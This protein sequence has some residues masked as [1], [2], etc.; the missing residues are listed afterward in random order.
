MEKFQTIRHAIQNR[1]APFKPKYCFIHT[2]FGLQMLVHLLKYDIEIIITSDEEYHNIRNK[3]D[4][5][6]VIAKNRKNDKYCQCGY[7]ISRFS[8]YTKCKICGL[9]SC[10]CCVFQCFKINKCEI[11]CY[12]CGNV[13]TKKIKK[14]ST[15]QEVFNQTL[16]NYVEKTNDKELLDLIQLI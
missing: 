12:K 10:M 14:L 8:E 4:S 1:Y 13:S 2:R 5:L 11:S 9:E 16:N 15:F 3:L 6:I 7:N